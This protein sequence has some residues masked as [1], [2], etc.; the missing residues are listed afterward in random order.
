MHD[1][2]CWNL[3]HSVLEHAPNVLLYGPP[4]TGK[5]F[6]ATRYGVKEGQRVFAVTL[7]E[8]TPAAELRG[9]FIAKGTEFV[10][11]DGPATMA[12]RI[13]ARLVINE[14]DHASGDCLDLLMVVADDPET[15]MMTLPNGGEIIRP[16]AGFQIVATM[17]GHPDDLPFALRDRFPVAIELPTAAPGALASLGG[18]EGVATET[19]AHSDP[20]RR[21]SVRSWKAFQSLVDAGIDPADAAQAIFNDRA[22]DVISA[23]EIAGVQF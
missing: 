13:G 10:W 4:G 12:E 20:S 5:T 21:V 15:S 3:A 1:S 14:I 23:L 18:L 16:S 9:H 8:E 22:S 2:N 17:N 6:A 7:T 11:M 19:V